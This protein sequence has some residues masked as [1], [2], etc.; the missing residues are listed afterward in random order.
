MR[1]IVA[2]S[3]D[4][5]DQSLVEEAIEEADFEP[6]EIVSGGADG[7]DA[8]G[9]EY[10]KDNGL[11]FSIFEA[12][13]DQHGNAAGPKRNEEMAK[14]AAREDGAAILV[15]DGES[16]GTRSMF[17]HAL[18][19][20]LDVHL[21]PV[22]Y[23]GVFPN[24]L[25]E[26]DLMRRFPE[27]KRIEDV[28]IRSETVT[29]LLDGHPDYIWEVPGA[30][31]AYHPA[32]E[33][34]DHGQWLHVKR[35]FYAYEEMARSLEYQGDIST[36]QMELGKAAVLFHDMFKNG[37]PPYDGGSSHKAH[38]TLAAEYIRQFTD[39]PEEVARLCDIHNGRWYNDTQPQTHHEQ[40]FHMAD[41]IASRNGSRLGVYEPAEELEGVSDLDFD[42][43]DA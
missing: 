7:V 16:L 22:G 6:T 14:Y 28:W 5:T 10:A 43:G 27:L 38:D 1:T 34:G 13:W 19:R 11:S 39:L 23:D 29:A 2:G 37:L 41:M 21:V 31:N 4:I 8:I 3:R 40:V 20:R 36:R 33:R 42:L 25:T 17:E 9:E 15:W 26:D 12:N 32:D 35:M 24:D 18:A 30:Q